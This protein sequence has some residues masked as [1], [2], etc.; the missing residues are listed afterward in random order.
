MTLAFS[1]AAVV[2]TGFGFPD[3]GEAQ[4]Q[5]RSIFS[6]LDTGGRS[7]A[8][9]QEQ[10]GSLT[11]SDP[12][13]GDG[14]RVQVWTLG[15]SPGEG[16]QVDLRSDDFDA[17][18]YVVGPGLAEGLSDDDAGSGLNSRLCFV[19]DQP[20]EYR[21]VA[22]SLRAETGAFIIAA[23]TTNGS[24]GGGVETS[25]IEDLA[26]FPTEG[27]S[28]AVGDE[29]T[30]RLSG[31]DATFYGSPA[32][33]WAIRGGS[34]EPFSVDLLS[35]DFDAFLTLVGPGLDDYLTDDDG[36]GR[37]DSR[38][39]LTFPESG[40]YRVIASTLGAGSGAYRL[41]ARERPG[42]SSSESCS[43][44]AND[45]GIRGDG[46]RLEGRLAD[47][48]IV[49]S[50]GTE[51]AVNGSITG[52]EGGFRDH[53]LQGWTMEG[54][55]GS[56]IALTLTSDQMDSY[57]FFDGPGFSEPLFNDD[58]AGDR[59]SRICVELPETGMY[60]VF[61]GPFSSAEPGSRYRLAATTRGAEALCGDGFRLS[62]G[63]IAAQLASISPRGRTIGVNEERT[64]TLTGAETH[65]ESDRP[66]Q[67]WTLRA[68]P[69]TFL[70][71]DV[72]SD[73]FDAYLYALP[74][75]GDGIL[76]ADDFGDG[77]NARMELTIPA[78]GEV[79]LL[80]S[81]FDENSRGDFLLRVATNPPPI[82]S[83]GC[84]VGAGSG[85]SPADSGVLEGLG[86]PV[87]D[88][89]LGAEVSGVLGRG[90][91]VITRGFAQSFNFEGVAG[92]EVVFELIS[93]DFDCYLYLTGPGLA[94]TLSDDDGAGN[95]DSRIEVT[96]PEGGTYTVVASALEE[97][98]T[99]AFRL[100]A[101][102][103]MPWTPLTELRRTL[104]A[105]YGRCRPASEHSGPTY[106][107][108]GCIRGHRRGRYDLPPRT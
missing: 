37:C 100:R 83:S 85:G 11:L 106:R 103:V 52:E 56:R 87:G 55:A 50:L 26:D 97:G 54:I 32:Q 58:G 81:A 17:F 53:P 70:Y 29:V 107:C 61:T 78:S 84:G 15:V 96:L 14:R 16:V 9:G 6:V 65:P 43:P 12:L 42:P 101:F 82:E 51:S 46:G 71:V 18:L 64:G 36:A 4:Q 30:G 72:V 31:S 21:V 108:R 45:G 28:F 10:S 86:V 48:T 60:R 13:S 67:P 74:E 2:L 3:P 19:P 98:S 75:G 23:S 99:G 44:P 66:I 20:G 94:G 47:I 73:V 38:I 22:S 92:Q 93:D 25:E 63:T 8:L 33:A 95:L 102:R 91:D 27:R 34:G 57:L 7:V 49:G 90:D 104:P 62:S 89:V 68:A 5:S 39:S 76:T 80:P 59:N 1:T 79:T 105:S 24:C 69:G 40:E 35:D 88:L 77:C 41:I